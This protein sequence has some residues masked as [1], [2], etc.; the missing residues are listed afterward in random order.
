MADGRRAGGAAARG[1]VLR[2]GPIKLA[3]SESRARGT[4]AHA[5]QLHA[6]MRRIATSQPSL[7]TAPCR[8]SAPRPR[9]RSSAAACSGNSAESAPAISLAGLGGAAPQH[10]RRGTAP[11]QRPGV[12]LTGC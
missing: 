12:D 2:R 8:S 3:P 1:A 7:A 9:L 5:P 11:E 6:Q 10:H 4:A